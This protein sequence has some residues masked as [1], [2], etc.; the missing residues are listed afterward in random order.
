MPAFSVLK[1]PGFHRP[2]GRAFGSVDPLPG[3]KR[4]NRTCKTIHNTLAGCRK[5][6]FKACKVAVGVIPSVARNLALFESFPESYVKT[7]SF[8]L[9]QIPHF[10]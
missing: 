7:M 4:T 1:T 8:D 9:G 5:T 2:V 6:H 10:V 3:R